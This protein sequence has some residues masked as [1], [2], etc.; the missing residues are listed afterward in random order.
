CRRSTPNGSWSAG[1][2]VEKSP[3]PALLAPP[4]TGAELWAGAGGGAGGPAGGEEL[5]LITRGEEVR[6]LLYH[7]P[8][9]LRSI[10][11]RSPSNQT[12]W[13]WFPSLSASRGYSGKR[14]AAARGAAWVQPCPTDSA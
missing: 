6:A 14:G 8:V 7:T 9:G 11:G 3:S 1:S 10:P 2:V 12:R 5:P 13:R 4:P